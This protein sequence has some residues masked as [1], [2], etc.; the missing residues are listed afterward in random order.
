VHENGLS[1][2]FFPE[3]QIEILDFLSNSSPCSELPEGQ[4][5][6]RRLFNV[7]PSEGARLMGQF[8]PLEGN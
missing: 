4:A 6:L 2:V 3:F 7:D 5:R 8:A 1:I